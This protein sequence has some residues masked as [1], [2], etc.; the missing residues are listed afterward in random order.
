MI[1]SLGVCSRQWPRSLTPRYVGILCVCMKFGKIWK[2]EQSNGILWAYIDYKALKRLMKGQGVQQSDDFRQ[3]LWS[4]LER[5]NQ[6]FVSAERRYLADLTVHL[7][8]ERESSGYFGEVGL[9][10]HTA[11]ATASHRC[12]LP[13]IVRSSCSTAPAC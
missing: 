8:G 11:L 6:A 1:E 4:E 12:H 3:A 10:H 7:S 13:I 2:Q 9:T 5:V